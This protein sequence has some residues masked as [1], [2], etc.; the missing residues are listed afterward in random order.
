MGEDGKFCEKHCKQWDEGLKFLL[1]SPWLDRKYYQRNAAKKRKKRG[2]QRIRQAIRPRQPHPPPRT[3]TR[4]GD[5]PLRQQRNGIASPC[6]AVF[7]VGGIGGPQ[8]IIGK[9]GIRHE[10]REP[11]AQ[12]T[13]RHQSG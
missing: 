7:G 9:V 2:S 11:L 1:C 10:N 8:R 13:A 4:T 5:E 12:C 3:L 6:T